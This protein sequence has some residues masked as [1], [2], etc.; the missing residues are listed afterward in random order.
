MRDLPKGLRLDHGYLQVR[1]MHGGVTYHKNFGPDSAFARELAIIHLAEKRKEILMGKFGIEKELPSKKFAD[2]ARLYFTKWSIE[3]DPEGRLAH[4]GAA[5]A[6]RV[7]EANLIP[8][9]GKRDYETIRPL[10]V[11]KWREKR[12]LTVLGTSVNREQAVLSSIFSHIEQW[13]KTEAI[14]A[15]KIPAENPC[16]SVE[17]APNRKRKRV[18]SVNELKNLKAAC[19]EKEDADLWEICEMALK[20]LLRK[21][22]LFNLEAGI[23]IDT[24]QAKTQRS[25]HLPVSVLHPLR[26]EN[27]RKRWEAVRK[28]ARLVDVQFRD[29]RKTGN[30][31]YK[32]LGYSRTVRKELLGH[33][34]ENTTEI[35]DVPNI[36]HLKKP[37]EDLTAFLVKL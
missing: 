28:A 20:S 6:G 31:I 34:N 4:G 35:Y 10:D 25:I 19:Y 18:L 8:H 24:I 21:K 15:F 23:D 30:N 12:L 14:P 7:I 17:K 37:V 9:F 33:A 3:L 22:D 32:M 16:A 2:V 5:E 36:D 11:V 27:F 13:V 29:L 26:Y 1:L